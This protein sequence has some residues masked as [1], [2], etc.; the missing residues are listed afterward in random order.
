MFF[1][2]FPRSSLSVDGDVVHVYR[3]PSLGYLFAEDGVYHHLKHCRGVSET[4]EHHSGFEEALWGEEG[5]L[6]LISWL[7]SDVVVS[8]VN[9]KLGE[10]GAAAEVIDGLQDQGRDIAVLL[11]PFI[12]RLV[13]LHWVQ[14]S[15][16]LFDKEEVGSVGASGFADCPPLQVLGHELVGLCYFILFQW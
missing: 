16:F 3:E 15:V 11:R 1:F 4:E 8:P 13:V 14:L 6:P 9:I 12:N 5:S 2:C 7:N 10:K